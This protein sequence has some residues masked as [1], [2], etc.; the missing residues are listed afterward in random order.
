MVPMLEISSAAQALILAHA[1]RDPGL[2]RCGLLLGGRFRVEKARPCRNVAVDPA[3]SFEVDPVALLAA[4]KA[5]RA[6]G[7]DVI[8]CWHSHP[9]WRAEPSDRDLAAA[10][11]G[12]VW[13]VAADGVLHAWRRGTDRFTSLPISIVPP[14]PRRGLPQGSATFDPS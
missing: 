9:N 11:V 7:P 2:E 4:H 12:S 14:A 8:G 5:A 3:T 6:G 1:A 13:I 10:E